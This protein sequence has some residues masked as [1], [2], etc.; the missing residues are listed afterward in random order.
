MFGR[1]SSGASALFAGA[2]AAIIPPVLVLGFD[3]PIWLGLGAAAGAFGAIWGLTRTGRPRPR[4]GL[5]VAAITGARAD[6]ARDLIAEGQAALERLRATA[7]SVRDELMREEIKLLTMKAERVIRDIREHPDRVMAVRRLLSFYLP[8]A[9]SVA[10]GWKALELKHTPAPEIELQ[11]R[12]TMAQLN[13]A[14]GQFA[15]QAQ[16]PQL[17]TLDL[18]L[19]VLRD[20]MK[21]DL[22][23]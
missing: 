18:D 9:A 10:E 17:Q 15:D 21:A 12:E 14:F 13:D 4:G 8:N 16:Q 7:R 23:R 19:K 11:T 20:A 3:Q 5:D 22:E 2:V 1:M 6:T